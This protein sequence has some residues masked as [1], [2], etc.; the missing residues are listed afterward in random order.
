LRSRGKRLKAKGQRRKDSG[1][2]GSGFRGSG[3]E[4][5]GLKKKL[6]APIPW[7]KALAFEPYKSLRT[8]RERF[9][10]AINSIGL[11]LASCLRRLKNSGIQAQAK[12]TSKQFGIWSF[13]NCNLFDIWNLVLGIFLLT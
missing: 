8:L 5:F 3:V 7:S 13:G 11:D 6:I 4:G 10:T 9:P 1:F 2:R 12:T